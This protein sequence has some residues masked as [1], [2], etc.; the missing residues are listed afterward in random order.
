M[1]RLRVYDIRYSVADAS[2]FCLFIIINNWNL[3]HFTSR[4]NQKKKKEL[5]NSRRYRNWIQE[6]C[7]FKCLISLFIFYFLMLT[8]Q[9][10]LIIT[11]TRLNISSYIDHFNVKHHDSCCDHQF[12]SINNNFHFLFLVVFIFYNHFLKIKYKKSTS[13]YKTK[14]KTVND[15]LVFKVNNFKEI[16]MNTRNT[17]EFLSTRNK[18][19]TRQERY[20][21]H[22]VNVR[23]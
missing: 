5:T 2:V 7:D 23:L 22:V 17:K 8:Y 19:A 9:F 18:K 20:N 11:Y 14:T 4:L 10:F 16:K 3:K 21:F 12:L 15:S 1:V 6:L 13:F